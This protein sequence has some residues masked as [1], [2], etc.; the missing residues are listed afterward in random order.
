MIKGSLPSVRINWNEFNLSVQRD[1]I[2]CIPVTVVFTNR[3][4]IIGNVVT[5]T[6]SC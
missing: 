3:R 5:V 4:I 1:E 2:A 6:S